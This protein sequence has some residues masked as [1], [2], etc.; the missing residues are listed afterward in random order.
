MALRTTDRC[1][2]LLGRD[3]EAESLRTTG[4]AIVIVGDAGIGKTALLGRAAADAKT[5]RCATFFVAG[6]TA[7]M[8]VP[9]S[10]L[11]AIVRRHWD[12]A[13]TLEPA[14]RETLE[15]TCDGRAAADDAAAIASALVALGRAAASGQPVL[16]AVDDM[17]R[18]DRSSVDV[19]SEIGRVAADDTLRVVASTRDVHFE[20]EPLPYASMV[21]LRPLGLDDA[22]AL[23]AQHGSSL[24]FSQR[25]HIV[26]SAQGNPLAL[27][28]LP[29]ALGS[30]PDV[31]ADIHLRRMALTPA[32]RRSF[33]Q[34]LSDLPPSTR[35]A[36]LIAAIEDESSVHELVAATRA[37]VGDR[38]LGVE[39]FDAAR[40]AGLLGGDDLHLYFRHPLMRPA[41]LHEETLGRRLE[42]RRAVAEV[43]GDGPRRTWHVAQSITEPNDA[44]GDELE[45]AY[46][47]ARERAI[48][49]GIATIERAAQ[50]TTDPV[51]RARRLLQIAEESCALGRSD[52]VHRYV[53]AAAQQTLDAPAQALADVLRG[54]GPDVN[55]LC[56]L[57]CAATEAGQQ[58][59]ALSLLLAAAERAWWADSDTTTRADIEAALRASNPP[60]HDAR[61]AVVLAYTA[62]ISNG[63]EVSDLIVHVAATADPITLRHLGL[64][65]HLIGDC[66]RAAAILAAAETASREEGLLGLLPQVLCTQAAARIELGDWE[67]AVALATEAAATAAAT[68]Q[69][70][71]A[72]LATAHLARARAFLNDVELAMQLAT[73]CERQADQRGLRGVRALSSIARGTASLSAGHAVEAFDALA[74]VF[75][76]MQTRHIQ[77]ERLSAVMLLV[78]AAVRTDRCDQ[79]RVI[80]SRHELSS[81]VT[82]SPL[83]HVQLEYARCLLASDED[84]ERS[85]RAALGQDLVRWPWVRARLELGFGTWLRRQRRVVEC[86]VPLRTACATFEGLGADA[87]A[88]Q[89]RNELRAAGERSSGTGTA[90][91][92]ALSP[93]ELEIALLA[94]EGLS[95][96]EIGQRLLLSHR[97]VG[98]HLYRIFPK[99]G[100]TSRRQLALHVRETAVA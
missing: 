98:A 77:R 18:L 41:V 67:R 56:R 19:I 28:E 13:Q 59:I 93:Q 47:V 48:V 30:T 96:R 94:A 35:D 73:E 75:D 12:A 37:F 83:L 82:P 54:G 65:A 49:S 58:G 46:C 61:V 97:T 85:Y 36:V 53:A 11:H 64:A 72:A 9:F 52:V 66:P 71:W 80:I 39:V 15:Q 14:Q 22:R 62:P 4:G 43:V 60:S 100:I 33:T 74:L 81:S 17:H 90:L 69:W 42:A 86:R 88:D 31:V 1:D 3:F 51:K 70:N 27:V 6:T 87:W 50:L 21:Y 8:T 2:L 38:T 7:R 91:E 26:R 63:A 24:T 55:E 20:T 68:N 5:R 84:A 23:V 32:L 99:L 89:A 92:Q 25:E 16:F 29:D 78:E 57:A 95:N 44:L 79:A 40:L 45:A 76:D 34:G 10:G